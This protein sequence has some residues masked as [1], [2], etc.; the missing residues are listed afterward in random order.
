MD[1][2]QHLDNLKLRVDQRISRAGES[3]IQEEQKKDER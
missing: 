1:I 3:I 2:M